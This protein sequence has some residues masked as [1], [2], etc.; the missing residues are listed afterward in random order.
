MD[1]VSERENALLLKNLGCV[2]SF[3][4]DGGGSST[5]AV[6]INGELTVTNSPSDGG[7]RS[8]ANHLLVVVPRMS[9]EYDVTQEMTKDGKVLVSGKANVTCNNGFT[10]SNATLLVGV[11]FLSLLPL[12][13]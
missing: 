5:F 2:N 1:G 9:V 3:N 10:Y 4:F 11:I 6:L 13:L 7:L 8:D 12:F